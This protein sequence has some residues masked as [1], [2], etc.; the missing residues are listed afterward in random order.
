MGINAVCIDDFALKKRQRYGTVMVDL[1]TH[2]IVDMIESRE[3]SDVSCWLSK[4][5]DLRIVSRDGS[6]TYAAAI[7]K[8]HPGAAQISDRFHLIKSLAGRAKQALQKLLPG[9]ISIPTTSATQN[10]KYEILISTI[11]GRIH[12]VKKLRGE[13]HNQSEI[14]LMTGLSKRIVSKYV[15]MPLCDIPEDKPTVR[16]REHEDAVIKL[17]GNAEKCKSLRESGLSLT[18]I[19]QKTGFTSAM[20]RNYLSADFSPVNGHYGKQREGKLEPFRDDIV[21]WKTEGLK[22]REI[23]E[24]IRAKGYLGSQDAIRVFISKERRIR[25]DLQA[26]I[27]GEAELVDRKWLFRLLYKPLQDVKGI[28]GEQLSAIFTNHPLVE[29]ILNIV[30]EF[31]ELLKSKNPDALLLWVD[32]ATALG[33]SALDAFINGLKQDIDAV[34]NA[35][36]SD[37]NN[38]LAEGT[39][40]KIKVIKRIMYGRCS[41]ELLKNKCMLL[42]SFN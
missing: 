23:H 14:S 30:Q 16:G 9:R 6:L 12:L 35:I 42:Q 22:Y 11:A 29:N 13:G 17:M 19:A 31:R 10:V 18:E 25:R 21:R 34:M 26:A 32:K 28:S 5:P 39:V 20:V 38:G 3:M 15:N 37:F 41:F 1:E 7:N 40:N 33:I 4:Y 27:G 36:A 2:K 8:S 24:R